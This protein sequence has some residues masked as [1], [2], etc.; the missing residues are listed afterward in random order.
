MRTREVLP[1]HTIRRVSSKHT[2]EVT[3]QLR[4]MAKPFTVL[5]TAAAVTAATVTATSINNVDANTITATVGVVDAGGYGGHVGIDEPGTGAAYTSYHYWA[6]NGGPAIGNVPVSAAS[7]WVRFEFYPDTEPGRH[8]Y[9]PWTLDIGGAHVE[10]RRDE[11]N[12]LDVGDVTLPRNGINCNGNIGFRIDGNITSS[13][14]LDDNRIEVD[15]FQIPT[16]FPDDHLPQPPRNNRGHAVKAFATAGNI[17][18]AWTGGVGW[19]GRYI[20]FIRDTGTG[21]HVTATTD[22]FADHIPTIDLDAWCFGFTTC[23]YDQGTPTTSTT[24]TFHPVTPTRIADTRIGLGISDAVRSGD[25]R[26]PSPNPLTRRDETAN[27]QLRVVGVGGIPT[28]G[29]AAIVANVT[30][31]DAPGPGYLSLLPTP[32]RVGDIFNDQASYGPRATTSNV[33]VNGPEPTPNLVVARVGAGGE[34]RL[35][36]FFG[37]SHVIVDVMGYIDTGGQPGTG[38]TGIRPTRLLDTRNGHGGPA[39]IVEAGTSRII[40]VTDQ[41]DVDGN[42]A[43]VVV[44]ITATGATSTGWVAAH[45]AD[46]PLPTASNLNV[47]A[48][49]TRANLAVVNTDGAIA[50]HVGDMDAHLVVDVVGAWTDN[51]P[52][53]TVIAPVRVA[54]TRSTTPLQPDDTR[55]FPIAGNHSIPADATGVIANV[56][57]ISPNAHSYLTIWPA[58][59]PRPEASSVNF[60]PGVTTPAAIMM[61]LNDVGEL[62]IYNAFGDVDVAIDVVGYTR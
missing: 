57:A 62:D 40:D 50:V 23:T 9:D 20:L 25:G 13:T 55:T 22:I 59:T 33:N 16:V 44:N 18:N 17:G 51:G 42:I 12:W 7:D 29:V 41:L 10:L 5:A 8:D 2:R 56:T 37:P 47:T 61:S 43:A 14:P 39:G 1:V 26:D 49:G 31:V 27:H 11:P 24:G 46:T 35:D 48:G 38:F 19:P 28:T 30:V 21:T 36:N 3:A 34:I 45:G 4:L 60:E 58:N 54:D 52:D 32:P 53:M 15:T 6:A